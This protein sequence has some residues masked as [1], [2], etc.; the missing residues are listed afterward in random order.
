MNFGLKHIRYFA[1]VAEELHFRRAAERL[2]LAQPALSRS[3]KH[4]ETQLGVQLLERSNRRVR[5][6][7][8]G[9]VFFA[10][11]QDVLSTMEGVIARTNKAT[12]GEL[13]HLVIGYTDFAICGE[14]PEILRDFHE[15]Y[16]DITIEPEHGFTAGQLEKLKYGNLDFG[17]LTGPI[18]HS[19]FASAT[20]QNDPYV[21]VL[22]ENHPLANQQA[23][24]LGDLAGEPIVLGNPSGWQHYNDHL[25]RICRRAGFVPEIAQYA[26][27]SEGIFGLVACE[28]GITIHTTCAENILRKGLVIRPIRNLNA[29]V[30][31][32]AVWRKAEVTSTQQLFAEFLVERDRGRAQQVAAP[33]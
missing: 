5:L 19:E 22:Y 32:M 15:R 4:L 29:T 21:A 20:V 33:D 25:F 23:I 7:H 13:G 12:T 10:G 24:D 11:C 8:A 2:N 17:F 16:P 14:L 6:T 28:M 27:N 30:P 3:V 1:A 18:N 31:T 26:F 9:A